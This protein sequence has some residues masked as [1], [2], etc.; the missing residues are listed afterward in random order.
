MAVHTYHL[1]HTPERPTV[2]L[3]EINGYD[4]LMI[5]DNGARAVLKLLQNVIMP[6]SPG[7][8]AVAPEKIVIS[9]RDYLLAGIYGYTYGSRIQSVLKCRTCLSPFDMDFSLD[10]LVLSIR[11][12]ASHKPQDEQGFYCYDDY[13]F[14]LPNGEDEM[15]V[16]GMPVVEAERQILERCMAGTNTVAND[17]D[18]QSFMKSVAPLVF[19]EIQTTCP[20]CGAN[21]VVIFDIQTF[22]LS[23][24]KNER[25][26]VAAEVHSI[27]M[28]YHWSHH[29][30]LEIPRT[31]RKSYAG[32]IGLE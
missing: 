12:S 5:E 29:E 28:A 15:A 8:L 6:P 18:V 11:G 27:A 17:R 23:R 31:L 21:Q 19:S 3:R 26:R 20:E 14:R 13:R 2:S 25:K 7:T 24:L 10:D 22:F 9:D 4:E 32:M 1:I 30:I 16:A